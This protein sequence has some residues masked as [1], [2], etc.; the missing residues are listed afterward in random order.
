M[1]DWNDAFD[2]SGYVVGASALPQMWAARA[3]DYRQARSTSLEEGLAYGPGA[4]HVFD[5]VHPQASPAGLVVFVHGGYWRRF[6]RS[7]WTD[8]A[9]GART[10][11]WAVALPS[12]TLAP[13]A[14][15]ADITRD[16]AAAITAAAERVD[17]PIR[18]A[19]HSAG[20]HLVTRMLVEDGPLPTAVRE[21]IALTLSISGLHDLRPL[22]KT[23]MNETLR[24]TAKE[25]ASESPALLVPADAPRVVAWVGGAERPEFLRQARLLAMMWEGLEADMGLVIEPGRNHFTVVDGLKSA[26]SP[27]T[28]ALLR[29]A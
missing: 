5:L 23:Q 11:G 21:R 13:E 28:T 17:G 2:N 22:L 19:G 3:A 16:V 14:R 9:E 4:R 8:L 12:Y 27:I 25:A 6:D 7:L 10:H 24:L 1:R 20:G 15:I 26:D 29:P 18:L